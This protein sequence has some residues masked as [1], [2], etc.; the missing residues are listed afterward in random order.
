MGPLEMWAQRR[1]PVFSPVLCSAAMGA[2]VQP[3]GNPKMVVQTSVLP[4]N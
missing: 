3:H 4:F 2:L 1:V